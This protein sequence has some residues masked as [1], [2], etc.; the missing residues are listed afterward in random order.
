MHENRKEYGVQEASQQWTI[1]KRMLE[2]NPTV[3]VGI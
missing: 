2:S 1:I 3:H